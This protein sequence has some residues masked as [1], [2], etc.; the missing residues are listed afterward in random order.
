[1][2]QIKRDGRLPAKKRK[3]L[4]AILFIPAL[5]IFVLIFKQIIDWRTNIQLQ[6]ERAELNTFV[7]SVYSPLVKSQNAILAEEEKMRKLLQQMERLRQEHPNHAQLIT[8]IAQIWRSGL[9]E[10]HKSFLET[11]KE[12]RRA[13]I[14]YNTLDQQDVLKKFQKQSVR[15]DI[16]NKNAAKKYQKTIDNI[17]DKLIE[18]L[19]NARHLLDAN[20]RPPRNKKQKFKVQEIRQQIIPFHEKNETF[21]INFLGRI[22][23]E[24]QK[25]VINLQN[26]IRIAAQQSI[27]VRNHLLNNPDLEAPLVITIKNWLALETE[28]KEKLNQIL[29]A[30]E[31]EYIALKLNLPPRNPAIRAMKKNLLKNIPFIVGK[32][33]KKKQSINQSYNIDPRR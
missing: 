24:L 29:Y 14:S 10:Y 26:L 6:Q 3:I 22:D 25:Q 30:I 21:L 17:Q 31:A 1:M 5:I 12:I 7:N 20:R 28:G 2:R 4:A 18:S 27:V 33:Q 13:W 23:Q 19:D 16:K 32:L 9:L 8:D 15:L 11:D